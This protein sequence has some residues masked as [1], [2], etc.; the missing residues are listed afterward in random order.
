MTTRRRP[1]V[2]ARAAW[3]NEGMSDRRYWIRR[4]DRG[5]PAR[6]AA[7]ERAARPSAR[8]QAG[9]RL[10]PREY[11]APRHGVLHRAARPRRPRAARGLRHLGT[12]RLVAHGEL[13]RGAYPRRDPGHLSLPEGAGDRRAAL[14]RGGHPCADRARPRERA[15]GA[16][17]ERRRRHARP[18]RRP[19]ADAGHLE[20]HPRPQPR[21]Q[22]GPRRRHRHHALAQPARLRRLQVRSAVGR[23]RRH[24][25]H[26]VDRGQGQSVPRRGA[27]RR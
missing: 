10:P 4:V 7:D 25:G 5:G 21:R 16:R 3:L 11:S 27:R 1:H 26:Q 15:R 2:E 12:S 9:A 18:R 20:G 19:D 22:G 24:R 6:D 14:P 17:R 23:P 8:G 13:Q